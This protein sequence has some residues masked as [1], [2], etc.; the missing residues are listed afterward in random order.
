MEA[1]KNGRPHCRDKFGGQRENR[2]DQ[3]HP[4][5]GLVM[6]ARSLALCA[7]LLHAWPDIATCRQLAM[8]TR[9]LPDEDGCSGHCL[10][11][12]DPV[13][14]FTQLTRTSFTGRSSCQENLEPDSFHT[15]RKI[16][17]LCQISQELFKYGLL[18]KYLH[19]RFPQFNSPWVQ[20][21]VESFQL[22]VMFVW[23][24]FTM[25]MFL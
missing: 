5:S 19:Y 23:S 2:Q 18:Y 15:T 7:R 3:G 1:T 11:D 4:G 10:N 25:L 13:F 21:R 17:S 14:S 24:S 22:K 12:S 8:A 6:D 9:N 20:A 16:F